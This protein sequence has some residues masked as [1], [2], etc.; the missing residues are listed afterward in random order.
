M[1]LDNKASMKPSFF[2]R[3]FDKSRLKNLISW[4]FITYGEY[5]TIYLLEELKTLGF[6]QATKAGISLS[7]DDLLI[8]ETKS[9]LLRTAETKIVINSTREAQGDLTSIERFQHMI[10]T[11][12]LTSE[13][14]KNDVVK[15]FRN[16]DTL[17]PVY[18]MAFSGARGNL[19]QV[20]QLVGMRGLMSDPQGQIIDFPITSNFREGLTLTEYVIS[21]YGARKGIVDTALRTA[22]SGYLTRRL[23]DV[24]QHVLIS[25]LDCGAQDGLTVDDMVDGNKITYAIQDRIIGR[26]LANDIPDIAKR[27]ELVNLQ[28]AQKIGKALKTS[29]TKIHV[30]VR[31][32]LTC[33]ARDAVCQLCYGWSLAHNE[34]VSLGE[35]V[36][37]IAAQSIGEPGTQLTMRT[38]HTGGVFSGDTLEQITAQETGT[39][40]YD[41]QIPGELVRTTHGRIAFLTKSASSCKIISS[42]Q[43][44]KIQIP[45]FSILFIPNETVVKKGELLAEFT[46]IARQNNQRIQAKQSYKAP[47]EGQVFFEDALFG[48]QNEKLKSARQFGSVW[49]LTGTIQSGGPFFVRPRDLIIQDAPLSEQSLISMKSGVIEKRDSK[50]NVP[51]KGI[52]QF[53]LA[54]PLNNIRWRHGYYN[55]MNTL[56][57][58]GLQALWNQFNGFIYSQNKIMLRYHLGI[59]QLGKSLLP[60]GIYAGNN[61]GSPLIKRHPTLVSFKDIIVRNQISQTS[62]YTV[63]SGLL[64]QNISLQFSQ[65]IS[66]SQKSLLVACDW[67]ASR[68]PLVAI[69]NRQN[70]LQPNLSNGNGFVQIFFCSNI[71]KT[72]P[73]LLPTPVPYSFDE[74]TT[75]QNPVLLQITKGW[76]YISKRPNNNFEVLRIVNIGQSVLDDITFNSIKTKIKL[77]CA[78]LDL[79]RFS[80]FYE[81]VESTPMN[82]L[83][84]FHLHFSTFKKTKPKSLWLSNKTTLTHTNVFLLEELNE[85]TFSKNIDILNTSLSHTYEKANS[86]SFHNVKTKSLF[87]SDFKTLFGE[88]IIN[89]QTPLQTICKVQSLYYQI[90]LLQVLQLDINTLSF[91]TYIPVQVIS[92][93]SKTDNNDTVRIEKKIRQQRLVKI[94]HQSYAQTKYQTF[95]FYPFLIPE[96]NTTQDVLHKK[97]N[98]TRKPFSIY[99]T[100]KLNTQVVQNEII[101]K[102]QSLNKF[103]GEVIFEQKE[104]TNKTMPEL[105]ILRGDHVNCVSVSKHLNQRT[106]LLFK[107]FIRSD[108]KFLTNSAL[109]HGGQV[110]GIKYQ[111]NKTILIIRKGRPVLF[112]SRAIFSINQ[113]DFV[114][115]DSLLLT[116]FYRRL[117]TGDIVQGIPKIEELFEARAFKGGEPIANSM[118]GKLNSL[119]ETYSLRMGNSLAV[120][121]SVQG[122][123]QYLVDGIQQVYQSQGVTISDKHLEIIVRQMTAKVKIIAGGQTGFLPGELVSL[124][125]IELINQGMDG[126]PAKYEPILLGITKASL[127]TKS[128]ISA[129]SFQET[130]RIL[131]RAAVERKTDF[132]KGLKENVI[133][134]H[135]IPAGTGFREFLSSPNSLNAGINEISA[136]NE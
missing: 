113:N 109:S 55:A 63:E 58:I 75:N 117:Q 49:L 8:P 29:S 106:N 121:R 53:S 97:Y 34:M 15:N 124:E 120:R 83:S 3:S 66:L 24:A 91:G 28:L 38:F 71:N 94:L 128:F 13:S 95:D 42:K 129:A 80:D 43:T 23:V 99:W 2:N 118:P 96:N 60:F 119:Y 107:K 52:R 10:D 104:G 131:A 1:K 87:T 85:T 19:S 90:S 18:M 65:N 126:A 27:N 9:R 127:E 122:I 112:S 39:L 111:D 61:L 88:Q 105:L 14:L 40:I 20:R 76:P 67:L 33:I 132:L 47:I 84:K 51:H 116:F 7:I 31:S 41:D 125:T 32:P 73:H 69:K 46:S 133:L 26:V 36:G 134:G 16:K 57:T 78:P 25:A 82:L 108:E 45:E 4:Y 92:K 86:Y 102:R 62:G 56:P 114:A 135:L 100:K 77:V 35:A 98:R 103:T 101:A 30:Q 123:Q 6:H 54:I 74:T 68:E 48:Y 72:K 37:I 44:C 81:P 59:N 5:Q 136:L 110:I 70:E 115:Q 17:N 130:T 21:C 64:S 11:W 12:H 22:N 79:E 50:W 93:H 89:R